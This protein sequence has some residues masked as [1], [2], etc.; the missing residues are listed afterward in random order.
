MEERKEM[1]ERKLKDAKEELVKA[2][3]NYGKLLKAQKTRD[4]LK[5]RVGKITKLLSEL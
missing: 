4:Y 2:E 5:V 3:E 1:L